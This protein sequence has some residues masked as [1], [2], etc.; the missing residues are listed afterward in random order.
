MP[1]AASR[2]TVVCTVYGDDMAALGCS[3]AYSG[4]TLRVCFTSARDSKS[5]LADPELELSMSGVDS[6][7]SSLSPFL[8]DMGRLLRLSLRKP[9]CSG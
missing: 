4:R 8:I 7:C 2:S 6:A 9:I 3:S 5:Y 1:L